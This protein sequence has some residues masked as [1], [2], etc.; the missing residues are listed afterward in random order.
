MINALL[1]LAAEEHH[2]SEVP[3]YIAGCVFAAWAIYV[4][5]S[6]LR[7]ESFAASATQSRGII[8]I[9]VVLAAVSMALAV[10]VS[11]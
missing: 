9:S 7:S 10:Y 8:L 4:G 5:V 2:R 3:F 6:G 1:I 11:N